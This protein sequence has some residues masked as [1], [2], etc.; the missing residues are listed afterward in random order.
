MHVQRYSLGLYAGLAGGVDY[1]MNSHV[2]DPIRLA[3]FR[4]RMMAFERA[5]SMGRAQGVDLEI[6]SLA[7]IKDAYPVIET[8]DL[9]G[10]F[11]DPDDG[12]ID[13][14]QP[15][16]A[17]AK[18]AREMGARIERFCPAVGVRRDKGKWV[19]A[20]PR[21]EIRCEKGVN[22]AGHYAQRVG[23]WFIPYG[24]WRVPM[25]TMSHQFFLIG[26]IPELKA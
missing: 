19:A 16:Q 18:G 4:A 12:D 2:K 21:G 8:H 20:T 10:G 23:E 22:A 13:P 26:E 11:R 14:A 17:L 5:K 24:R 1:P 25:A 6:M 9:K 3:L 15:T 7:D